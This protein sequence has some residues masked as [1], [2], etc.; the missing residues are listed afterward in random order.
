[1]AGFEFTG[2]KQGLTERYLTVTKKPVF[3]NAPIRAE[4]ELN[5]LVQLDLF[6]FKE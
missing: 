3:L 4:R 6:N 5:E 2:K 1:M